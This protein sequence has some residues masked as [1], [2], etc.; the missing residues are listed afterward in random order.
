M[1]KIL[2]SGFEILER[3]DTKKLYA[4]QSLPL[5]S[6]K[7]TK[8]KRERIR[9][10]GLFVATALAI[11][12]L[13]SCGDDGNNQSITKKCQ[14]AINTNNYSKVLDDCPCGEIT[15]EQKLVIGIKC[16]QENDWYKAE[17]YFYAIGPEAAE[18]GS[19]QYGIMLAELQNIIGEINLYIPMLTDVLGIT[20]YQPQQ[21]MDPLNVL[22]TILQ[23]FID[24]LET[25]KAKSIDCLKNNWSIEIERFPLILGEEGTGFFFQILL[26]GKAGKF[27]ARSLGLMSDSVILMLKYLR[28]HELSLNVDLLMNHLNDLLSLLK[29]LKGADLLGTVRGFGWFFEENPN[30]LTKSSR[31]DSYTTEVMTKSLDLIRSFGNISGDLSETAATSAAGCADVFCLIDK[32]GNGKISNGDLLRTNG[33]LHLTAI[34]ASVDLDFTNEMIVNFTGMIVNILVNSLGSLEE[35]TGGDISQLLNIQLQSL[36][37]MLENLGL[38]PLPNVLQISVVQIIGLP[39]GAFFDYYCEDANHNPISCDTGGAKPVFPYE[40][41]LR[42][43]PAQCKTYQICGDPPY[44]SYYKQGDSPHFVGTKFE[45]PADSVSPL[46]SPSLIPTD[47]LIYFALRDP[48]L[49][50]ALM[51]NLGNLPVACSPE[52]DEWVLADNYALNKISNCLVTDYLPWVQAG[53]FPLMVN[54]ILD[55]VGSFL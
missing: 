36:N 43:I 47:I 7:R 29:G 10:V 48:T 31:W 23:P 30:F 40:V 53:L 33:S 41:E 51:V 52:E 32:D 16:L 9:A 27:P 6:V 13:S 15:S 14:I 35:M 25:I 37:P 39:V 12:P 42:D 45:I 46:L 5:Q 21:E 8:M 34:G 24:R 22:D 50:G 54:G 26:N 20:S 1:Q 3:W 2:S 38:Q 55:L 19:A 49:N 17:T 18:Y 44:P 11:L 4:R 28:A